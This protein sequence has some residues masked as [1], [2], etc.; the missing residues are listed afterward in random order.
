[1][2]VAN[3]ILT[4]KAMVVAIRLFGRFSSRLGGAVAYWLWFIP[5]RIPV[6]ERGSQK[7][8]RWLEPTQPFVLRT[9]LGRIAGFTAGDGPLVMLVHGWGERA[10]GLGG[11]IAPLTDAG[12]K[13]VGVDFLAHGGSSRQTTN[14]IE[15][16]TV[17]REVAEHFG[18]AHAVIAHSLGASATLWA[19]R[20]GLACKRAVLIAPNVDMTYAME[21]FQ[22]MFGLPP[23]AITGLKRKLE[24]RFG[25]N[26]WQELG[27]DHLAR[28]NTTP[29]LVFHDPDDP[30]IPFEGSERLIRAWA[31][32]RLIE[33]PG[34]GH[35]AITR[36]PS[37][38]ERAVAFVTEPARE[39]AASRTA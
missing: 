4:L 5:W 15:S 27:G 12:Y 7:Q 22:G 13:V 2:K 32:S 36:D 1:M 29:G 25:S 21:T 24:R 39:P 9:S 35:G 17:M 30:Q 34:L 33:A 6:S 16:A 26:I 14:P 11:F 3:S 20:E 10:A 38:I 23:K 37:V 19:M 8:A 28:D 31:G 18:G